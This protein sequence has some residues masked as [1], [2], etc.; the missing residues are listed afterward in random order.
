MT[1]K[2][3][4]YIKNLLLHIKPQDVMVAKAIAFVD[5]NLAVY[6]ACNGQLR[7]S[8]ESELGDLHF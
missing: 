8:Y 2:E 5:K 4:E 1:T 3:L 6:K 7:E